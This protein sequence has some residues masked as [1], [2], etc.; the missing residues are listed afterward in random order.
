L[1]DRDKCGDGDQSEVPPEKAQF[2]R[3]LFAHGGD[4]NLLADVGMAPLSSFQKHCIFGNIPQVKSALEYASK[5]GPDSLTELLES[6]ETAMRQSPLMMIVSIGKNLDVPHSLREEMDKNQ[7]AVARLLLEYGARPDVRDVC[8]KTVCHYGMG[9]MATL[10]M[11]VKICDMC[12]EAWKSHYLCSKKVVLHG[13]ESKPELN[14]R[15]AICKGY[16]ADSGRRIVELQDDQNTLSIKP[17]NLKLCDVTEDKDI[18]QLYD[19]PDR[20]GMVCLLEVIMRDRKDI[21]D[22]LLKKYH[23]RLDIADCDGVSPASLSLRTSI[24]SASSGMVNQ[25]GSRVARAQR[26]VER[27]TCAN[28]GQVKGK[29]NELMG[30]SVCHSVAYCSKGCQGKSRD[31]SNS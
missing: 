10:N 1:N 12:I 6:R 13:L 16:L 18:P 23:A 9:C 25:A 28:C 5:K 15:T 11:T 7:V 14:G 19:I 4:I 24:V 29:D 21:A 3:D 22:L 8:G 31:R 20:I 26:K 17:S 2:Y 27:K 30:C